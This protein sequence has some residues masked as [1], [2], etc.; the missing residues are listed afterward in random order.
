MRVDLRIV[1]P[2]T[3]GMLGGGQLGR[4]ALMAARV[5]GY[6]TIVLDPDP[7][8][9]AVGVADE[10]L[11]STWSLCAMVFQN[12]P[13]GFM[14]IS[15]ECVRLGG[16]GSELMVIPCE[17]RQQILGASVASSVLQEGA[18]AS[19]IVVQEG[20]GASSSVVQGA[21]ASSVVQKRGAASSVV[22]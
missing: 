3:I 21:A 9:P 16:S 1:P 5:M 13:M 22:Q 17:E 8:A 11:L 7:H 19:S 6:R 4:Y 18:G 10:H 14:R 2:A 12:T 20:A 15:Y